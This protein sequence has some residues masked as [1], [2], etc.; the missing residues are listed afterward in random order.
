VVVV[1][2]G[3]RVYTTMQANRVA[4]RHQAGWDS[5][6]AAQ[7]G[8]RESQP[9]ELT[10]VAHEFSEMLVR[11]MGLLSAGDV[12]YAAGL[13]MCT[14]DY[15]GARAKWEEAL[16]RYQ[17]VL[18]SPNATRMPRARAQLGVGRCHESVVRFSQARRAYQAVVTDYPGT[19]L[20][21]E[22]G[23]RLKALAESNV[24]AKVFYGRLQ[25]QKRVEPTPL[26]RVTTQPGRD[27]ASSGPKPIPSR[28]KAG[29][30]PGN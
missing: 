22:A 29:D 21:D 1:L 8:P 16:K 17:E 26:P 4:R 5:L 10:E 30:K 13:E 20:A 28:E 12:M 14:R 15:E 18:D 19:L 23:K 25:T 7:L 24:I 2:V 27:A 6:L 11:P 3:W 9:A